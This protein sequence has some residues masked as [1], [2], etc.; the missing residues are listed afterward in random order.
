M[1]RFLI[2]CRYELNNVQWPGS[3]EIIRSA[4]VVLL[5][6]TFFVGFMQICDAIFGKVAKVFFG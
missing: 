6:T 5:V 3:R 1:H 4:A 2:G